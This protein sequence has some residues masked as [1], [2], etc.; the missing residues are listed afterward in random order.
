MTVS[1]GAVHKTCKKD[2]AH[3]KLATKWQVKA[4]NKMHRYDQYVEVEKDPNDALCCG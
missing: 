3:T 2:T 1:L 4:D